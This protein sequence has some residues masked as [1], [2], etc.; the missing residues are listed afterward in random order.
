MAAENRR[1]ALGV[2]GCRAGWLAVRLTDNGERLA[3]EYALYP[4]FAAALEAHPDA[5]AIAVDMPIGLYESGRA[6]MRPCDKV[7]R[8]RLGRRACCVFIPPTREMLDAES[9]TPLRTL[10]LSVQAYHLIPRIR[11]LDAQLTPDLQTRVWESHPELSFM[12]LTGAPIPQ[13]K[14][15]A[16]GQN[17]RREAL[18]RALGES[19]NELLT[20]FRATI[21]PRQ[22]GVDD[23]LDACALAWSTRRHLQGESELCIGDPTHD[24][25]GLQMA[26]RY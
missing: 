5:G 24:A 23:L 7:A 6:R 19:V 22:A 12:A 8:Q 3:L 18:S 11:E 13:P 20:A 16:A 21:P 2:D 25:R 1:V 14:R 4:S 10:G 15:T 9:Y 26:I 17:A